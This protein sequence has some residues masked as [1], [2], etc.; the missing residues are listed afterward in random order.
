MTTIIAKPPEVPRA[1]RSRSGF[2]L[3]EVMVAMTLSM[4]VLGSAY[5]TLLSL[6]KGSES[7]LNYSE[8]NGQARVAIELFGRDARMAENILQSEPGKKPEYR[9]D[10]T[11][12]WFVRR[13]SLNSNNRIRVG[14]S[15]N[16]DDGTFRR[17]VHDE[18]GE[19]IESKILIYHVN[20]VKFN[21][22]DNLG[23]SDRHAVYA[24]D[25][26]GAH[27]AK[28]VQLEAL[29]QRRVLNLRNTNEILSASFVMRNKD[30][31]N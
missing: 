10:A 23:R 17:V 7:M 5:A 27:E 1:G 31:T 13:M 16:P 20:S 3:P 28:Q 9:F 14:Y 22:Y 8:M 11:N 19:L 15:F 21:Y 26:M 2:S 6:S 25:P 29:V 24:N 4:F 30:D 12:V 18:H